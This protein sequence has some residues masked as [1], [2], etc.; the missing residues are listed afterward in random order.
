MSRA[1]VYESCDVMCHIWLDTYIHTD[2][3]P[4]NVA[5]DAF[6]DAHPMLLHTLLTPPIKRECERQ[7]LAVSLM[8]LCTSQL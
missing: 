5:S 3:N 8:L 4:D 7:T 6:H 2:N 1:H